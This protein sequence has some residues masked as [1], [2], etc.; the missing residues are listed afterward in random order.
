MDIS[1]Q[2]ENGL[3]I[4]I[5]IQNGF[6]QL[7]SAIMHGIITPE[8]WRKIGFDPT[9]HPQCRGCLKMAIPK[10]NSL[11]QPICQVMKMARII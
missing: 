6:I 10:T 7:T 5:T 4:S 8:A 11:F 2:S 3:I 1:F 9:K